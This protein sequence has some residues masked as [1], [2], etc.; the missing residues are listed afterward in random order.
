METELMVTPIP[1]ETMQDLQAGL[2]IVP[3]PR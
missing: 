1:L 3:R 2:E